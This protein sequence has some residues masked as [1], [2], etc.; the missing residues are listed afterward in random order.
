MPS[1][2][3]SVLRLSRATA[4]YEVA[5]SNEFGDAHSLVQS[6]PFDDN[7]ISA[8]L[9]QQALIRSPQAFGATSNVRAKD[10]GKRLF[11]EVFQREVL[12]LW[13]STLDRCHQ[14]EQTRL[15]LVLK[16]PHNVPEIY[17][18]PWEFL[19]DNETYVFSRR[20]RSII[21]HPE[22]VTP[23]TPISTKLPIRILV[24]IAAPE[25]ERETG[26]DREIDF[27]RERH[28]IETALM[29]LRHT[30]DVHIDVVERATFA[31]VRERLDGQIPYHILHFI[32]HG[33]C[34][35]DECYLVFEGENHE[36]RPVE[37]HK[38]AAA[39]TNH[40][41]L[42]VAVLNCCEGARVPI[43]DPSAAI[44][45]A[46]INNQ[47]PAVVSMQFPISD[48]AAILFSRTFYEAIARFEP[49][50][51]AVAHARHALYTNEAIRLPEWGTP[52]VF[53]RSYDGLLFQPEAGS[54]M[55]VANQE[56]KH[57]RQVNR[58]SLNDT[59]VPAIKNVDGTV[60][61]NRRSIIIGDAKCGLPKL[62]EL[63]EE[64][65]S[66][67]SVLYFGVQDFIIKKEEFKVVRNARYINADDLD[68][69]AKIIRKDR[70]AD[71]FL[72]L[73]DIDIWSEG[74][75]SFAASENTHGY[76]SVKGIRGEA[77]RAG[78]T[79]HYSLVN[80]V[81]V[82]YLTA[83]NIVKPHSRKDHGCYI[84]HP[85]DPSEWISHGSIPSCC[86]RTIKEQPLVEAVDAILDQRYIEYREPDPR[87][88]ERKF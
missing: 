45:T 7:Q 51:T 56:G 76:L 79:V 44:S 52:V 24:V 46:L 50:D 40:P 47:L 21:R 16:V 20:D 31:A 70:Q 53:T 17:S 87:K 75:S 81:I 1:Y 14:H 60:I 54:R 48:N 27:D 80:I 2:I 4:G 72:L 25:T 49:I 15:R 59:G 22:K 55:L 13:Q 64:V 36:F 88:V 12:T 74:E 65:N 30:N 58:S 66:L 57:N 62:N 34:E 28:N 3:T 42:S 86:R 69:K 33:I 71:F 26:F 85:A 63:F 77:R 9:N 37:A 23:S 61:P 73:T 8:W 68:K 43:G 5:L 39:I 38:F 82:E 83:K 10:I 19:W 35:E 41:S 84:Q 78:R 29:P 6:N 11:S 67:Q 18:W 32:G